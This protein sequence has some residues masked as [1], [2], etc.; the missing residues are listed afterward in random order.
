MVFHNL[1]LIVSL[2][3]L[4]SSWYTS[5]EFLLEGMEDVMYRGLTHEE[6]LGHVVEEG[7]P[8]ENLQ[9]YQHRQNLRR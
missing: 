2:G 4:T 5:R 7:T 8:S 3:S 6:Q 1:P 9:H